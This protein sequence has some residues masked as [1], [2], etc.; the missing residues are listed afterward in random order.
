VA[1]TNGSISERTS[2]K[3]TCIHSFLM[4]AFIYPVVISWVWG[5][6]W[7][8]SNGYLDFTGSG[9]VHCTGA[10]AGLA[11]MLMVGPRYNR[12]NKYENIFDD[13]EKENMVEMKGLKVLA[14]DRIPE[15]R[16]MPQPVT[17]LK[18]QISSA[19]IGRLRKKVDDDEYDAFAISNL[20]Y[21]LFGGLFLW[22]GFI[23]FNAGSTMGLYKSGVTLWYF[24]ELAAVNT[25]TA[26]CGAGLLCLLVKTPLMGGWKAPRHLRDEAASVCNAFLAG[27]VANGAGMNYYD[28]WAS[29]CVG[30]IGCIFYMLLCKLF[31]VLQIDDAVEAV[32]LHGGGGTAGVLCVAYFNKLNGIYYGNPSYG[33]VFGTQL[34]GWTAIVLWSFL[35][36]LIIWGTCRIFGILRVDLKTEVIGYDFYDFADDF[37]FSG[38]QLKKAQGNR[39]DN[40]HHQ[41]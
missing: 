14:L 32:Q 26:G 3:A 35:T 4:V 22:L 29:W 7:L 12:W 25:F 28:P 13:G 39:V 11:G 18:Q 34:M 38:K 15:E 6:G 23:F 8:A 9:V 24:A 33:K 20:T 36:G 5:G 30:I 10:A 31:D 1:I 27:M 19:N 41:H 16:S 17:E 37:D 40:H 2:L 21:V